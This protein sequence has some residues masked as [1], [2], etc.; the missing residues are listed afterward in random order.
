MKGVANRELVPGLSLF[1]T[2]VEMSSHRMGFFNDEM[3]VHDVV[4]G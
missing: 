2:V 3:L 1:V 4:L